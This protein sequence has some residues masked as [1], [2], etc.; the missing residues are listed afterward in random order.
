MLDE[1]PPLARD[2]VQ[3]RRDVVDLPV[4]QGVISLAL[5]CL[6]P[7]VRET[8]PTQLLLLLKQK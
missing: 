7:E 3:G 1:D 4:Y 6:A 8:P 5:L 2:G